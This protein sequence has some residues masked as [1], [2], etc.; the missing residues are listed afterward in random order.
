[1]PC[2]GI[3]PE[4]HLRTNAQTVQMLL[5]CFTA[6][7]SYDEVHEMIDEHKEAMAFQN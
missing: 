3:R 5:L 4:Y 1:M 6:A 7:L 2:P